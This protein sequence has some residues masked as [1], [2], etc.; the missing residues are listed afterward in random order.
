[1][2][3][4]HDRLRQARIAAKLKTQAEAVRRFSWNPN[5]YKSNENGHAPF[6]YEQAKVYARAYKVR[7]DWL[8]DGAGNMKPDVVEDAIP[9]IGRVAAGFEGDFDEDFAGDPNSWLDPEPS[10]GRIALRIEG[11]SMVPLA[12]P[13]DI[14]VFGPRQEDPSPLLN[15]RVMARLEDGRKLFKVL[16]KGSNE[17][18]FSLHSL[19]S[20]YN[21]IE[22]A[23]LLWVLPLER[24][25][26]R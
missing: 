12:H 19:N 11:D 18:K 17:G 8:Y 26:I 25:H 24:I 23:E 6:S 2:T 7:P 1:M 20:S 9:I 15:R 14:A 13:G 10:E 5:T 21:P 4:R 16:R 22:D 3:E